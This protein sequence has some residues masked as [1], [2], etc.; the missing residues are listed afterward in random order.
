MQDCARRSPP[1]IWVPKFPNSPR[2]ATRIKSAVT[3]AS[4]CPGSK[5]KGL[6]FGKYTGGVFTLLTAF[7]YFFIGQKKSMWIHR[8]KIL[9]Q[10]TVAVMSELQKNV[11]FFICESV[12]ASL[13]SIIYFL[14][15]LKVFLLLSW[16]THW[17]CLL[18]SSTF[19]PFS[20]ASVAGVA[21]TLTDLSSEAKCLKTLC[22]C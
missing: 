21:E 1:H 12:M 13:L 14:L 16:P 6:A 19:L 20:S 18:I 11:T 10:I 2:S 3:L 15:Y 7:W 4:E 17:K 5:S 8:P 9:E 22:G